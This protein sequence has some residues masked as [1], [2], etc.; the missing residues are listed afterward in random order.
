[1]NQVRKGALLSFVQTIVHVVVN[2][3][4]VPLLLKYIGQS[5]YGL[6]QLVGS[7]I[8]YLSI[9]QNL[10]SAGVLRYYCKYKSLDDLENAENTLAIA[11][12]IYYIFSGVVMLLGLVMV[13]FFEKF[14][15]GSLTLAEIQESRW[16]ILLLTVTLV[17]NLTSYVYTA[18]LNGN[19]CFF[20][21][22]VLGIIITLFQPIT[23]IIFTIRSPYA[24]T[25]V[26]I[27]T[28]FTL[29]EA[30]AKRYY[31]SKKM[32]VK[33]VYHHRD[34]A[35]VKKIIFF[36]AGVFC[37]A[38]ADQIFWKTDQIILGR[39]F[40]TSV[41][42]VYAVGAQIYTNYM[43]F[44][45]AI[46]GVFMPK[47]SRI[48]NTSKSTQELSDLFSKVGRISFMICA[49]ILTGFALFG[50]D[51][52]PL[53]AGE[54]FEIAYYIALTV[55]FPFTID[56]IQ[57]L[58]LTILQVENKYYFR[59]RMYLL[60]AIVNI[61]ATIVFVQWWGI[62]GAAIA[63]AASSLIGNGIIM[64]IYYSKVIHLNV[65]AF[66]VEILKV[67]P[68]IILSLALGYLILLIRCSNPWLELFVHIMLYVIVYLVS[69]YFL[70]L[71]DYEKGMLKA[72]K[73]KI[74]RKI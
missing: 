23:V 49:L 62:L 22:K 9:T 67:M 65:K 32:K 71:N 61:V 50:L 43:P 13:F 72:L 73:N 46:S 8:A 26:C 56:I 6:Y 18:A 1:M 47:V 36:S 51:F 39:M 3:L 53:W 42:A 58:G 34:S 63:T 24:L 69:I 20:F 48:Y 70:S 74:M 44:G 29:I 12:R 28:V 4:Y 37:A 21:I 66:W 17:I 45:T 31:C 60:I 33:I 41:V 15:N 57:N 27:Q 68:A 10:L 7:I 25:V 38:L 2:L 52:I 30:I 11:K 19:E 54:N 40:N 16:M 5:E 59:A 55:M 64:N 14:Y 35:L